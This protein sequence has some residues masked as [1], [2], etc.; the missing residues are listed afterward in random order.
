MAH[1]PTSPQSIRVSR[2]GLPHEA[3]VAWQLTEDYHWAVT[4]S[5]RAF[6][7]AEAVARDAF[8]ALCI[9]RTQL[10]PYDWRIGVAG[11]QVDVWP[12]GM[13][14]DQGSGLKAYRI[15][16]ERVGDLVDTFAPVDPSTVATVAMQEA[17]TERML[18]QI[19]RR[20]RG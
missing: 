7:T 19:R 5:S 10:E 14:R 15:T 16:A 12:S 4:I 17:E 1:R 18:N 3:T 6:G 9:V 2:E 11:A 13:A 20:G 8:E